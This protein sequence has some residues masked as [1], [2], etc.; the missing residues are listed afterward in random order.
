[1]DALL[2]L[3]EGGVTS[4]RCLNRLRLIR[5]AAGNTPQ[6]REFSERFD[7]AERALA[8]SCNPPGDYGRETRTDVPALPNE[9]IAGSPW[10][11]PE[12]PRNA[13]G[14]TLPL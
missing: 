13:S 5:Q 7:A 10:L 11:N 2:A 4:A 12:A 1:M 14:C 6:A 8:A 3:E 9:Q